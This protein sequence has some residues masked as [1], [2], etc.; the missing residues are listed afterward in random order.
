MITTR[1]VGLI[2]EF[3]GYGI[4]GI[5]FVGTIKFIKMLRFNNRFAILTLTLR[6]VYEDLTGFFSVFFLV[7]FAFVQ[8][9][10]MILHIYML[11]FHTVVAALE[12]WYPKK[13]EKRN[14]DLLL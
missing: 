11:E 4:G 9:F 14:T 13:M 8:V 1:Y 3:Y 7:F 2:D 12:T 6:V 5:L 10:Y